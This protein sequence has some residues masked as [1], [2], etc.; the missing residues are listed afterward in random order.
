MRRWAASTQA[1]PRDLRARPK[2]GLQRLADSPTSSPADRRM[3]GWAASTQ[4]TPRG[5]P[6]AHLDDEHQSLAARTIP[7]LKVYMGVNGIHGG[8]WQ[9]TID[10]SN[11]CGRLPHLQG[12]PLP[13]HLILPGFVARGSIL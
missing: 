6:P 4:A 3:R 9:G 2:H 12:L 11:C 10:P 8:S 7:S 13:W 5:L 1:P